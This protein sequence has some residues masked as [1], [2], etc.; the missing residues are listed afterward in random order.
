MASSTSMKRTEAPVI[1]IVPPEDRGPLLA[2]AATPAAFDWIV[3]TSANAVDAF[4]Q[5]VL[6]GGRDVRA[7]SGPRLCTV[8]PATADKLARYGVRV[9]LIPD[10]FRAE[11]VVRAL[12]GTGR[13]E[14]LRVLLPRADIGREVIADE[15]RRAGAI[16]TDVVAYRTVLED[17]LPE[18][19]PDVYGMLLQGGIDVVTFT[20]ASAVRGFA[21]IY[22]A[23]QAADLLTHTVVAVIG[24]TTAEAVRQMGVPVAVQP[25]ESTIPA[26]VDAIAAH[27]STLEST[28]T[29]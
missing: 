17:A 18:Q 26:L 23:E 13:L 7:L 21:R 28:K 16:V 19:G 5:A 11:G 1:R 22:G 2:A 12:A 27:C 9:D 10:E 24:P 4:M 6:E 20:S 8:G 29:D 25:P 3:L 14:G 15:L